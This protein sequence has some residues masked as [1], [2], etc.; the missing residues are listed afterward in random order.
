MELTGLY[1][2]LPSYDVDPYMFIAFEISDPITKLRRGDV[3]T[4]L[5]RDRVKSGI[6]KYVLVIPIFERTVYLKRDA[7]TDCHYGIWYADIIEYMKEARLCG[8]DVLILDESIHHHD[9]CIVMHGNDCKIYK[10]FD[11]LVQRCRSNLVTTKKLTPDDT[12]NTISGCYGIATG[13]YAQDETTKMNAPTV[14]LNKNKNVGETMVLIGELLNEVDS[15]GAFH[16]I[17]ARRQRNYAAR[18]GIEC[19]LTTTESQ[20][21]YLEGMRTY[22]KTDICLADG[23]KHCVSPTPHCDENNGVEDG[24]NFLICFSWMEKLSAS[25]FVRHVILGYMRR[26]VSQA[27]KRGILADSIQTV[28]TQ[29]LAELP[30]K[31][32]ESSIASK[33]K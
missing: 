13:N 26:V 21:L 4:R 9:E 2:I 28:V 11:K 30:S 29:Y 10:S 23:K 16:K 15:T 3:S 5:S 25:T 18:I 20:K 1:N 22:N 19:G 14:K 31:R 33:L 6:I 8:V 7:H 17:D 27:I 12:R 32:K 24:S